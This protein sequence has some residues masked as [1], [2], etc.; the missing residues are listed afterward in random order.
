MAEAPKS[1]RG[2]IQ[3]MTEDELEGFELSQL[4]CRGCSGYGNCG[5]RMYRLFEGKVVSIC[6]LQ[7]R[8]LIAK[9]DGVSSEE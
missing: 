9:R 5:Y 4:K 3:E 2:R 1:A 8:E 7:K 6:Q